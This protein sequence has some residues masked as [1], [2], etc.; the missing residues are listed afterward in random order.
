MKLPWRMR[1]DPLLGEED[2]GDPEGGGG[3]AADDAPD[4]TP[5]ARKSRAPS[6]FGLTVLV[7]A[8]VRQVEVTLS[9]GDYVTVPPLPPEVLLD[10]T[11]QFDPAY[12]NVQWQRKPHRE[13]LTIAVP[14]GRGQSVAVPNSAGDQRPL[15]ALSIEA[16]AR[17]YA[18]AE[19]DGT[20]RQLRAL[21]VMV[22][23]R[24]PPTRRRFVDVTYAF[25]VRLE[26]RCA[27]GIYPRADMTGY[28]SQDRPALRRRC[29]A[30]PR[31]QHVGRLASG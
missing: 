14:D 9:W 6:S 31:H 8:S 17:Q 7:D 1:G 24:R 10:E 18:I 11:T 26:V 3:R 21:T 12:R 27:Q 5:A 13:T 16:H 29:R 4:D 19:P 28:G 30:C 22:V 2:A 25:Q 23:N 20:V 15:G